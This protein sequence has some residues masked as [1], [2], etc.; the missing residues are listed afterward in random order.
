VKPTASVSN[1]L[2][3]IRKGKELKPVD[4]EGINL[5]EMNPQEKTNLA[6]MLRGA[7]IAR[8]KDLEDDTRAGDSVLRKSSDEWD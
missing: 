5:D 6:D 3:D 8:R 1:L 7:M 4:P 2:A